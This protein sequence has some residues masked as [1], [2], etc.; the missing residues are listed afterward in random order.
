MRRPLQ[1]FR[2][3]EASMTAYLKDKSVRGTE[4][5]QL[6][7]RRRS[8]VQ[9]LERLRRRQLQGPQLAQPRDLRLVKK[10]LQEHRRR[11]LKLRQYLLLWK[12]PQQVWYQARPVQGADILCLYTLLHLLI[13]GPSLREASN[14][15]AELAVPVAPAI[16]GESLLR[17]CPGPVQF[18]AIPQDNSST[19]G[20]YQIASF[21]L[22][23]Q[24]CALECYSHRCSS[25]V[26]D[27]APLENSTAE[28]NVTNCYIFIDISAC[29]LVAP[30]L[31][32]F[33]AEGRVLIVCV[34]CR[35]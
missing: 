24:G 34:D 11:D 31:R 32:T 2:S 27:P 8:L 12:R 4:F 5:H 22:S 10:L 21:A 30:E 7:H 15:S 3:I 1:C 6:H 14:A 13:E 20:H 26:F 9:Q 17:H 33:Q 18:R 35:K 25:A 28:S 29:G 16:D 23:A 19:I